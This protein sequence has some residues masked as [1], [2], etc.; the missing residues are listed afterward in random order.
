MKRNH[1]IREEDICRFSR[2]LHDLEYAPG[3]IEKYLRDLTAFQHWIGRAH[4]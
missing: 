1:T 3:S 4:V 2:H